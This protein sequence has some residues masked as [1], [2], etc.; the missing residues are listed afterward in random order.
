MKMPEKHIPELLM[1]LLSA[2][3]EYKD[4]FFAVCAAVVG[5][6]L[7]YLIEVKNGSQ[8]WDACAFLLA[9]AAAGFFGFITYTI[10]VELFTWSPG[11]SVAASG[12]IAHLGADKVKQLLT[13]FFTSRLK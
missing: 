13:E 5:G 12:M 7:A 6:A 11:L 10:C 4:A 8:K 2:V 1:R 3:L 9:I